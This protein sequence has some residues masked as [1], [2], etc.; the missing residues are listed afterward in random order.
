LDEYTLSLEAMRS[1][2]VPRLSD[3]EKSKI[4]LIENTNELVLSKREKLAKIGV[5]LYRYI[6]SLSS[7]E[8][9]KIQEQMQTYVKQQF[10]DIRN[11]LEK[12]VVHKIAIKDG[13]LTYQTMAE[14][15]GSVLNQFSMDEKDG[16]L[17]IA[18]T[19]NQTWSDLIG[20]QDKASF[21]NL[22]V[23]DDKLKVVGTLSGLAKGERLYSARFIGNR[24]YLVTFKQVDPLFVIDLKDPTA[25]AVL[26]ELKIPGFS[27]YLHPY[28]ENTLIGFGKDTAEN[29]WGGVTTGG[30][31]LSLFDVSQVDKPQ[32]LDKYVLGDRGSDSIALNDH[33]AFLFSKE[34]NILAIP[35][36]LYQSDKPDQWGKFVFGGVAV[37]NITDKKF[38][39]AGKIDH[40]DNGRQG[41]SYSSWGGYS[42]YD[43]T[44]Q[45]SL[46]IKDILYTVSGRYIKMNTL[47][48]LAPVGSI[49]LDEQ[50]PIPQPQP[51]PTPYPMPVEPVQLNQVKSMIQAVPP[52]KS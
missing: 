12:T 28:D 15:S 22:Y 49:A 14:V 19:K 33:R 45:R 35:V 47:G 7:A 10:T 41:D 26:G 11:E 18:T 3:R 27:N 38:K 5:I 37:F 13:V 30:L 31:K 4:S 2:V 25:P 16:Y 46:Y 24:A 20:E 40:S 39:L 29:Q 43:S 34:K 42:Y 9:A 23:L 50:K 6:N 17:R 1:I 52:V 32:E 36:S 21:N 44:V 51:I 8:Q 48:S